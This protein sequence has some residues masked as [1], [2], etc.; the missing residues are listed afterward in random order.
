[1]GGVPDG[2]AIR[3]A[4]PDEGERLREIS[5]ASKSHW[6]YEDSQVRDWAAQGDFSPEAMAAKVILVAEAGG[7]AVGFAT[8][9]AEGDLC[10]LDDL[11]LEP[12]WI[13]QGLGSKLFEACAARARQLGA[14]RLEWEAEPNAVGFYEKMG[15]RYVRDSDQTPFGRVIP[16]MG[17]DLV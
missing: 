4:R 12:D 2:L 15:G 17:L 9:I 6:G 8:L 1:V 10:V 14:R 3:P 7:R 16:V 13:G 11:W 5:I